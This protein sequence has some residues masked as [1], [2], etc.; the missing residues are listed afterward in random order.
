LKTNQLHKNGRPSKT[1]QLQIQKQLR[2]YFELGVS[3]HVASQKTEINV[4]T[5][6]KYFDIWTQTIIELD[7]SD[8]LERQKKEKARILLS[9]EN[10][11][12]EARGLL[13]EINSEIKKL[14][15][16]NKSIPK[17]FF[18][19][20]LAVMRYF[21]NLLEKRGNFAM[22]PTMD[23]AL[24]KKISEMITRHDESR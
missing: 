2:P 9:L 22:Q 11:I 7:E 23:S 3:A 13:D 16:Q 21:L 24:E 6:C 15:D 4:K 5:V 8:F 17:Q 14:N 19:Q 20:K 1:G 10:Q 12:I 18:S